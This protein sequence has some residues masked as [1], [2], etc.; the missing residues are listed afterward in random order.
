M[1]FKI[2]HGVLSGS[3]NNE[4]NIFS[5]KGGAKFRRLGNELNI[6][7]KPEVEVSKS[8]RRHDAK[9]KALRSK[10]K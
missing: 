7:L 10:Q 8:K 1:S 2:P 3:D 4:N 9:S 5:K 6:S